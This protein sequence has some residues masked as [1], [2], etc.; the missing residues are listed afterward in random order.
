MK[1]IKRIIL[2]KFGYHFQG[3]ISSC[4]R[5]DLGGCCWRISLCLGGIQTVIFKEDQSMFQGRGWVS[6]F[7]EN[8]SVFMRDSG[9]CLGWNQSKFQ[10]NF[11]LLFSNRISLC[12]RGEGGLLFSK[13]ISLCLGGIQATI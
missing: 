2:E 13:R 6:V 5:N 8:Q 1:E 11:R 4:L 7:K 12:F 10:R 3:R 9:C